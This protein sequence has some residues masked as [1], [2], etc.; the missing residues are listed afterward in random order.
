MS[1]SKQL[2]INCGASHVSAAAITTQSG[3]LQVDKLVS[4][5]L[6]YDYSDDESWMDAVSS[7][8]KEL[9]SVH[10]FGGKA[11]FILPGN[12]LLTKTF[13][14]PHVEE[15]KRAQIIAFEAQQNIPYPLYEVVW[16]SQVVGDDGVETEEIGRASCRERV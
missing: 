6:D 16:D 9:S 11:S 8:L 5:D 3:S 4:I 1:S 10:K 12:Q 7:G 14:I 13:R 2:I 15:G